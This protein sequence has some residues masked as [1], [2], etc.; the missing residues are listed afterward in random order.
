MAKRIVL[1][2]DGTWNTPENSD[3]GEVA[4]TN[5]YRFH[6]SVLARA[7]DGTRQVAWYD[8]G[9]GT[10]WWERLRGGAFGEGL[11]D[12]IK[13]GYG[14]LVDEYEDGDDVF[15]L[16]FS[17]GAYS[18]RSLAGFIRK[19]GLPR[20]DQKDRLEDAYDLYR[21]RDAD[22]DGPDAV[23]FRR[24][25]SR[26]IPILFLGVWDTVGA[27]GIP[28]SG[29]AGLNT[30]L[31]DFHDTRLSRIVK[32]A[33]HAVAIDEHRE[34]FKATLWS[35][36]EPAP[37]QRVEQRW[38][39]GAHCNVGGGYVEHELSDIALRWMQEKAQECGL[40]LA[41][42]RI[43]TVTD[44]CCRGLCRDSF[45]EFYPKALEDK[46]TP[47]YREIGTVPHGYEKVDESVFRRFAEDPGY[48][49]RNLV[50]Y[51]QRVP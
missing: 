19:A 32:N 31:F 35:L 48:R 37:D 20:R 7:P 25:H 2:F 30:R 24:R 45:A 22:A 50:A 14:K 27:L 51:R 4:P 16:G 47:Y 36:P 11:S 26:E 21:K 39:V 28:I 43:A 23:D 12:N 34:L 17:R 42:D 8:Q 46:K 44:A 40:A 38:F 6:N 33:Y 3:H 29:L 10:S 15:I 18:A 5:V 13:Q 9:V 1:S 41:P 49:P